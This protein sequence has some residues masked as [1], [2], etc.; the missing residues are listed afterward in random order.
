MLGGKRY[1]PSS[2]WSPQ[3]PRHRIGACHGALGSSPFTLNALGAP[4]ASSTISGNRLQS[5]A[6]PGKEN[7]CHIFAVCR[8]VRPGGNTKGQGWN[9]LRWC[10]SV[11]TWAI[12]GWDI[13]LVLHGV[14]VFIAG[15]NSRVKERLIEREGPRPLRLI[16]ILGVSSKARRAWI[17]FTALPKVRT[18]TVAR[19]RTSSAFPVL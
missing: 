9:N 8:G 16:G 2:P 12:L 1:D 10:R 7:F 18:P 5:A 19:A 4:P 13:G 14:G 6:T 3:A 17:V 11:G 15:G